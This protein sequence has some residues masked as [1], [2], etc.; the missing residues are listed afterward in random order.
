[1]Q[2]ELLVG[3]VIFSSSFGRNMIGRLKGDGVFGLQ[4]NGNVWARAGRGTTTPRKKPDYFVNKAIDSNMDLIPN[5]PK[6]ACGQKTDGTPHIIEKQADFF[7]FLDFTKLLTNPAS[8]RPTGRLGQYRPSGIKNA[9][10]PSFARVEN[11][12]ARLQKSSRKA[13]RDW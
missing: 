1:M 6:L 8:K 4:R 2:D 10:E 9:Y 12:R 11:L 3:A 13:V 7:H 5:T